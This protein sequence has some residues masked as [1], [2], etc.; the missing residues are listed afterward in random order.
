MW[1]DGCA[2]WA[3]FAAESEKAGCERIPDYAFDCHT[4]KGRKMGK[5]RLSSSETNRPALKPFQP[6]CSGAIYLPS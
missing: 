5:T 4:Q 1:F 6:V 3:M 2:Q